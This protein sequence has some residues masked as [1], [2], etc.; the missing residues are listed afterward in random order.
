[1]EDRI[2]EY[3]EQVREL[4]D[5][6]EEQNQ[7]MTDLL[8]YFDL[9][10]VDTKDDLRIVNCYGPVE[11]LFKSAEKMFERGLSLVKAVYKITKNT[12]PRPDEADDEHQEIENQLNLEE[13]IIKFVNG[14]R[15][16][17]EYQI[18]GETE[19]GD[20]FLLIWKIKRLPRY[21]RSYFKIIPTNSIIKNMQTKH[22]EEIDQ[23]K[24]DAKLVF[25]NVHDGITMLDLRNKVL[26]M[27]ESAK[28]LYFNSQNRL[29]K[30]ANFEGRLFQEIFVNE[31]VEIVKDIT[32]YN[33]RILINREPISYTKK[34]A[35][36]EIS[37][38]L[39]PIFNE[40]QFII[41][42]LIIS[43]DTSSDY[44]IDT[45]KLFAALKNLSIENKRLFSKV[46][47]LEVQLMK[48]NEKVGDYQNTIKLFYNFLEKIPTPLSIIRLS[49]MQYEFINTAFETKIN[50]KK[51]YIRG[52]RDEELFPENIYNILQN[53]IS[54][55]IDA[56]QPIVIDDDDVKLKQ[57]IIFNP[58]NEPTHVI[59]LYEQ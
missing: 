47:E 45:T 43:R 31:D 53:S 2:Q 14:T 39:K 59:R 33:K 44:N 18:I 57:S 12:R 52:K 11:D 34:I 35:E 16:E 23:I 26:Y 13:L 10:I 30:N 48:S 4:K 49:N 41:G 50:I 22:S 54:K 7:E 29:T 36:K 21:F 25:E 17:K 20:V 3:K 32:E 9:I 42:V 15:E 6:I 5:K 51:E 46:K 28:K 1:M 8:K 58:N 37:F 56:R 38:H 19:T 27:N 40:R 24:N 55:S